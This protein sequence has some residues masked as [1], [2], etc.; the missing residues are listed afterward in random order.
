MSLEN[1]MFEGT[2]NELEGIYKKVDGM[3]NHLLEIPLQQF[4]ILF[5]KDKEGKPVF[6]ALDKKATQELI[7][8]L[9]KEIIPLFEESNYP[10]GLEKSNSYLKHF[11]EHLDKQN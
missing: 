7:D 2:L 4:E 5:T 3:K 10:P 1:D 6:E 9:E 8:T 11:Q